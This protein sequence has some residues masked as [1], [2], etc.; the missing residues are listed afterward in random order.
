MF[1]FVY[2]LS[3]CVKEFNDSWWTEH[4][5]EAIMQVWTQRY[6]KFMDNGEDNEAEVSTD[7]I[8]NEVNT[9]EDQ[10]QQWSISSE[11][12]GDPKKDEELSSVINAWGDTKGNDNTPELSANDI[13]A[14]GD[15]NKSREASADEVSTWGESLNSNI[16]QKPDNDTS[17]W[18]TPSNSTDEGG[19]SWKQVSN[20][21]TNSQN[22]WGESSSKGETQVTF[23]VEPVSGWGAK[24]VDI[25]QNVWG[26]EAGSE[27]RKTVETPNNNETSGWE[28]APGVFN[29]IPSSSSNEASGWGEVPRV[30]EL[31]STRMPTSSSTS[32][33]SS[34]SKETASSEQIGSGWIQPNNLDNFGGK[35]GDGSEWNKGGNIATG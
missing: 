5:N 15:T 19:F 25:G 26:A 20:E 23:N 10:F 16:E 30:T 34:G 2:L 11:S 8:E 14:W 12:R 27:M 22:N 13:S 28:A 18:G 7:Q 6:G 3:L 17:A 31:V 33:I 9:F 21:P 24:T 1:A 32:S 29:G 4:G 35:G